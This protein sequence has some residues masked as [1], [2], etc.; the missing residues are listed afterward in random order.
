MVEEPM[1]IA[2]S[3]PKSTG[4]VSCPELAKQHGLDKDALGQRLKRWRKRHDAGWIEVSAT[5]RGK[6]GP[7]FLYDP[8]AVE[9]LIQE[10][11]QTSVK[12]RS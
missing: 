6:N 1:A 7:Q 4:M 3:G 12:R 2:D 9:S 5:E 10:L 11:R 8:T